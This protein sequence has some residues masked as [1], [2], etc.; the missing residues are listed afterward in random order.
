MGM[1]RETKRKFWRW[2]LIFC[3]CNAP[4]ILAL[5]LTHP[6]WLVPYLVWMS[7]WTWLATELPTDPET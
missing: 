1:D 5:Q 2:R 4:V 6:S 7:W 3:L